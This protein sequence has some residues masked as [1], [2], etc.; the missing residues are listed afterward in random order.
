MPLRHTK[1][2]GRYARTQASKQEVRRLE[3]ERRLVYVHKRAAI[4]SLPPMCEV[5]YSLG[6]QRDRRMVHLLPGFGVY[7][8]FMVFIPLTTQA[9]RRIHGQDREAEQ[10][11]SEG[12]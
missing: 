11:W 12:E 2:D 6:V 7:S 5:F 3:N 1:Q 9:S 10:Y 4:L 8:R